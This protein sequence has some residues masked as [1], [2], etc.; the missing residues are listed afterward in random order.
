MTPADF[1]LPIPAPEV[2]AFVGCEAVKLRL[3]VLRYCFTRTHT[4]LQYREGDSDRW[5]LLRES[6]LGGI[7]DI[8]HLSPVG[9][10]KW[11][12]E[13]GLHRVR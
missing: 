10:V 12:V 5:R 3:P 1:P 2:V 13:R 6:V 9:G 4:A 8:A 7:V 11:A